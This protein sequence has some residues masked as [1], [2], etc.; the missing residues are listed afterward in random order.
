MDI[1]DFADPP[2]APPSFK[3]V[4]MGDSFSSGEGTFD[5]YYNDGVVNKC[6]K[7]KLGYPWYV[8]REL[9]L[10]DPLVVACSGAIT[11]DIFFLNHD[12]PN[13]PSQLEQLRRAPDAKVVTL[14][15]GG[16]DV[17]FAD[18][19]E[20]CVTQ[21]KNDGWGCA[22]DKM[23]NQRIRERMDALAGNG[24]VF[25]DNGRPVHSLLEVYRAIHKEAPNAKIYVGGYPALF[26]DHKEDYT[27]NSDAP[28]KAMCV[29]TVGAT[30]SYDDAKWVNKETKALD[31]IIQGSADAALAEGVPITYVPPDL[32]LTHA[33]CDSGST[34]INGIFISPDDATKAL[35]ESLHPNQDGYQIGY[36]PIFD[37]LIAKG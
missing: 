16:N 32:F 2:P 37:T 10:G 15:L 5:Y 7:S 18:V 28:G 20:R 30:I 9:S 21:P 14:T 13:E 25:M 33:Q 29:L 26:G 11:D 23:V 17:G 27:P 8:A 6:H 22:K 24:T 4:A 3:Y 34:W 36:G 31:D 12:N 19:L 1:G 35:P